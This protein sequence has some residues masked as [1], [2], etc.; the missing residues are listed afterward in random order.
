VVNL[1]DRNRQSSWIDLDLSA[2]GIAD[3]AA[4]RVED[5]LTGA[6]YEWSGPHNFVILDPDV[7]PAHLFRVTPAPGTTAVEVTA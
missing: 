7:T 4:Y 1:D 6:K 3:G 5:L 2:L